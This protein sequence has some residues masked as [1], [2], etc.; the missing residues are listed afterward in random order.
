MY[1][2]HKAQYHISQLLN[3]LCDNQKMNLS[4]AYHRQA[5]VQLETEVISWHTS[6][7]RLVNS[8]RE[9]VRTLCR[10]IKL[11]DILV[12]DHR[13][14]LHASA[15]HSLCDQWQLALDRLP[16]KVLLIIFRMYNGISWRLINM[17]VNILAI[18]V[19]VVNMKM[20][21]IVDINKRR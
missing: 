15:V 3:H 1:E 16:D 9:Y 13:H 10:W 8:Q 21:L 2:S 6:F 14:S 12:D 5:A 11:T 19:R 18:V 17:K 4:T 20:S 7:C